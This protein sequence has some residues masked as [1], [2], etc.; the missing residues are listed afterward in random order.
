MCYTEKA[1][2]IM[3]IARLSI[4]VRCEVILA[5]SVGLILILGEFSSSELNCIQEFGD[6]GDVEDS[7]LKLS[8][9]PC[10][11]IN[12]SYKQY[13]CG[14]NQLVQRFGRNYFFVTSYSRKWH[15]CVTTP[16]NCF[17]RSTWI[18]TLTRDLTIY[19]KNRK[20]LSASLS[21]FAHR[22]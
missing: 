6:W 16:I 13:M 18:T 20:R 15:L 21:V 12:S 19:G 4:A 22:V 8:E 9:A 3:S 7:D 14:C 10:H 11:F 2:L 5:S 17:L 1:D